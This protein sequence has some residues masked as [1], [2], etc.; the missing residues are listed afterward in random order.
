MSRIRT[1]TICI[2]QLSEPL[3]KKN[4]YPDVMGQRSDT[5]TYVM[6]SVLMTHDGDVVMFSFF[7]S[8][9]SL[10]STIARSLNGLM[11]HT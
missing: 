5:N 1:R 8:S 7:R 3:L 9:V 6:Y 2:E 4:I 11:A 10:L